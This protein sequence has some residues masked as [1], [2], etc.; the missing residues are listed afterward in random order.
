MSRPAMILMRLDDRRVHLVRRAQLLDQPAVD[1]VADAQR[2]VARLDVDVA[3]AFLDGVVDEVVDQL[4]DRRVAGRLL[5][6]GDVL[7]LLLDRA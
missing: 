7:D 3:G 6:V 2:V 4:D 1:A 5:E